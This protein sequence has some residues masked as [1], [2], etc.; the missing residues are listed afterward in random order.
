MFVT[1]QGV[2][3]VRETEICSLD[4]T[5]Q[6]WKPYLELIPKSKAFYTMT[7]KNWIFAVLPGQL[8]KNKILVTEN[9][10]AT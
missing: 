9:R 6:L 1:I 5:Q 7:S 2:T 3:S 8:G 4:K 10:D